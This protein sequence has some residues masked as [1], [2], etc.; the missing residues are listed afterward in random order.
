MPGGNCIRD[1]KKDQVL[2]DPGSV[3]P[4]RGNAFRDIDTPCIERNQHQRGL[5]L[6]VRNVLRRG[7]IVDHVECLDVLADHLAGCD[8]KGLININESE[9]TANSC[10]GDIHR[11]VKGGIKPALVKT[12]V[13]GAA[14]NLLEGLSNLR[15]SQAGKRD[16]KQG[17][18]LGETKQVGTHTLILADKAV[19]KDGLPGILIHGPAVRVRIAQVC[20]F[21]VAFTAFDALGIHTADVGIE[22]RQQFAAAGAVD[23]LA[24][25]T[26]IA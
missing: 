22:H 8:I 20:Q 9:G 25:C 7:N 3:G 1:K 23:Q 18:L 24:D 17:I 14:F 26:G 5:A 19:E 12:Q 11:R 10:Q 15:R 6:F 4:G 16:I 21:C 13:K 2:F